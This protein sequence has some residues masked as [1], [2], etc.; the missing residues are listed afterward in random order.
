MTEKLYLAD[1]YLRKFEARVVSRRPGGV[2][3]D[4]TAFYATSGGQPHD[5]GT[6]AG[7]AVTGVEG[8]GEEVVHAVAGEIPDG[9]VACEVD[10]ARRTDHTEQHHGQH[11]LS[12]AFI[13]EMGAETVSFHLGADRATIDLDVRDLSEGEAERAEELAN[14]VVRENRPVEVTWHTPAEA[15][16]LGL[17][18]MPEGLD[19]VR[20]VAIRDFD[21]CACGGT[22]PA[23]TGDV[24]QIRVLGWEKTKG[25][26]RVTFVCGGRALRDA[27]ERHRA[28]AAAGAALGAG[29]LDAPVAAAKAREELRALARERDDLRARAAESEAAALLTASRFVRAAYPDREAPALLVLTRFLSAAPE[30]V[31]VVT[32]KGCLVAGCGIGVS[33]DLAPAFREACAAGTVRGGGRGRLFQAAGGTDPAALEA[34]A[35]A[36]A[37]RLAAELG[38]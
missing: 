2:V 13:E 7:V 23:R 9:P 11:I 19:R 30:A 17:R 21:R 14:R 15:K 26:V 16:G 29:A 5:T 32:G 18:K 6:I 12:R 33:H 35:D 10:G 20:V 4:R 38:R 27:R 1:S 37:K 8:E 22:H 25:R 36:L 28:L 34:A 24:G 3:L 31:F